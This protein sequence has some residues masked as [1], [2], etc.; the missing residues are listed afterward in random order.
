[1]IVM[2]F[3]GWADV[4]G[5]TGVGLVLL[6]YFL[7]QVRRIDPGSVTFSFVNFV[8]A[9]C[10]AVSLL[11][12]WNLPSMVIEIAW[13]LLSLLGIYKALVAKKSC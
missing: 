10:I 3:A 12:H 6:A 1:M 2:Q 4:V 11:C 9:G 13:I 8:G 5:L 7:L